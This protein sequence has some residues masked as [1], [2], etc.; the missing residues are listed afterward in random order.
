LNFEN[1]SSGELSKI[2]HHFRKYS[3]F[4]IDVIKKMS[5][6]KDMLLN[7]YSSKKKQQD[8]EDF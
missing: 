8:L 7:S 2:G 4:K 1:W 5:I 3:G 6:T